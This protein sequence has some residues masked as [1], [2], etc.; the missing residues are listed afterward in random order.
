MS[1]INKELD[2]LLPRSPATLRVE[3]TGS[4]DEN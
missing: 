2:T 3:Y 1:Q 4:K